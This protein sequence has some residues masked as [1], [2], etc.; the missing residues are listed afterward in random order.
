MFEDRHFKG[1]GIN[2]IKTLAMVIGTCTVMSFEGDLRL[3]R[4][5]SCR[6]DDLKGLQAL[7]EVRVQVPHCTEHLLQSFPVAPVGFPYPSMLAPKNTLTGVEV[8]KLIADEFKTG[9]SNNPILCFVQE[10]V[11]ARHFT[12]KEHDVR[13]WLDI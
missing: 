1:P 7:S 4:L 5:L 2:Q 6:I 10:R 9:K 12:E 13:Q 8:M 11:Q 3:D